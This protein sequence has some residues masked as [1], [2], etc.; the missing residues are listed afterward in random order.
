LGSKPIRQGTHFGVKG[1]RGLTNGDGDGE[2][3][4]GRGED[5]GSPDKR[6]MALNFGGWSTS[7][8]RGSSQ[9]KLHGQR[10]SERVG[11]R[12]ARAEEEVI[13]ETC[14]LEVINCRFGL[15]VDA[16]RRGDEGRLIGRLQSRQGRRDGGGDG[17]LAWCGIGR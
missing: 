12:H 2:A 16:T 17:E 11:R 15:G 4:S 9:K 1:N 10:R 6:S 3:F 5:S 13:G 8:L 14:S 7:G